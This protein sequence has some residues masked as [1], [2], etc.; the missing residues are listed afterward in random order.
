MKDK[1]DL[2]GLYVFFPLDHQKILISMVQPKLQN[3]LMFS[4]T[5]MAYFRPHF[6]KEFFKRAILFCPRNI[7]DGVHSFPF[8]KYFCHL[9]FFNVPHEIEAVVTGFRLI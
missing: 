8:V 9:E 3:L 4:K 5:S 1:D 6:T 7:Y 2:T